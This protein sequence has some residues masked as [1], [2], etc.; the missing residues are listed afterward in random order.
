MLRGYRGILAALAGL[1]LLSANHAYAQRGGEQPQAQQSV[2]ASLQH[3]AS[4]VDQ[5]TERAKS[6]D[7]EEQPCG[8]RQYGSHAD[9]CAQWKAADAAADSA[10]WA[11]AAGVLGIISLAGVFIAIGLTAHSNWIA[12]DTARRQLRA[13]VTVT[14]VQFRPT[15]ENAV[16]AS[17]NFK[18]SGTTPAT[19][20][21]VH[22]TIHVM[23]WDEYVD[24]PLP[25]KA[26]EWVKSTAVVGGGGDAQISNDQP[27][28]AGVSTHVVFTR[29]CLIAQGFIAYR[30]IFK[31]PQRTDFKYFSDATTR[32]L[33]H[34]VVAAPTGNSMS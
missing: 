8:P 34:G 6:A 31:K 12:R 19:D 30:D 21:T 11:W 14:D 24:D 4:S 1:A 9:L 15:P 20:L 13:Y 3:I 27:L 10:W 7:Q 32:S 5:A 16:R 25:N 2:A 18:N 29:D 22:L 26:A 28:N 23:R 33:G 17:V